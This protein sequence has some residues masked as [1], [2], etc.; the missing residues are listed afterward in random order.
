MA[1]KRELALKV[2]R[3]ESAERTPVGFWFHFLENPSEADALKNPEFFKA[4][5]AGH[6]K[7]YTEF[8]PDVVKIMSDGLFI[9]P[10]EA[11]LTAKTPSDLARVKPLGKNHPWVEK[12]AELVRE[13]TSIFK[14]EVMSFYNIFAPA[15]L[16]KILRGGGTAAA[17]TL[18]GFIKAD[19][20][21]VRNALN[22]AAEDIAQVARRVIREGGADGIYYSTQDVAGLD[23]AARDEAVR[24]SDE[25]VLKS[26]GELSEFNI[27]HICGYEGHRNELARYAD[28]PAQ[29]F[30]WAAAVEGVPLGEGKKLFGGKPVIGGFGNTEND[31]LYNGS[32]EAVAAE[33]AKILAEAGR[34]G[35][36]LGADCTVPPDINYERFE[37]VR[38]AGGL[39]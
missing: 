21:A 19:K 7:F 12:Q 4:N 6:R 20:A 35:V 5:I 37:W 2:L 15:T 34:A 36:I 13:V 24:P 27:L 26:A 38:E 39:Q 22:V 1:G 17:D 30:N 29:I 14:G 3:N 31:V 32:R 23:G 28:Y 33:T 8:K 9:Y 25:I 18:A 10:N 16:F 11:F